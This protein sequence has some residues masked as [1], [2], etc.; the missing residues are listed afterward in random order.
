MDSQ[1]NANEHGD[2]I[3]IL[4]EQA[5][6]VLK[7]RADV[8]HSG[9]A[10]AARLRLDSELTNEKDPE[11]A[12]KRRSDFESN[13][14]RLRADLHKKAMGVYEDAIQ[15][16]G[17]RQ[18]AMDQLQGAIGLPTDP[19]L[20]QR[21]VERRSAEGDA[22]MLAQSGTGTFTDNIEGRL[23]ALDQRPDEYFG[24]Q[25]LPEFNPNI[26]QGHGQNMAAQTLAV[27]NLQAIDPHAALTRE[28]VIDPH[29]A[30]DRE[31]GSTREP[32]DPRDQAVAYSTQEQAKGVQGESRGFEWGRGRNPDRRAS[33]GQAGASQGD[34]SSGWKSYR[35]ARA[36]A[37]KQP[38]N[39]ATQQRSAD[40]LAKPDYFGS[41]ADQGPAT[42][43][44]RRLT[45]DQFRRRETLVSGDES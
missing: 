5:T 22:A 17:R 15:R 9:F 3:D 10:R 33:Q 8:F 12:R 26:R 43:A 1:Q 40:R 16:R 44:E 31:Q 2:D 30:K 20:R 23:M 25:R 7:D 37:D 39:Q 4:H 14:E 45:G 21:E 38:A 19:V 42:D 11:V 35:P 27:Q 36:S 32:R 28:N 41:S 18:A 24:D 6:A 29:G 34:Q 13:S